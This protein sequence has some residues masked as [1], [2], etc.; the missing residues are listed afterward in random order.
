MGIGRL[1]TGVLVSMPAPALGDART[2]A[3]GAAPRSGIAGLRG[4]R[5]IC[6]TRTYPCSEHTCPVISGASAGGAACGRGN[7]VGQVRSPK[8]Q[9]RVRSQEVGLQS[10]TL[11]FSP[12]RYAGTDSLAP[13]RGEV[14]VTLTLKALI[15]ILNSQ[16]PLMKGEGGQPLRTQL[17]CRRRKYF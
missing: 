14:R 7:V 10:P 13:L 12:P 1:Q 6:L 17:F 8:S 16:L 15:R 11:N 2:Q 4:T 3:G 9:G 5:R